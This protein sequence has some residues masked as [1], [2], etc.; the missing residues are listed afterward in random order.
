[1]HG[2]VCVRM[3]SKFTLKFE[4][5]KIKKLESTLMQNLIY[6]TSLSVR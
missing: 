6:S 3:K 5:N 2:W 1:M 4:I